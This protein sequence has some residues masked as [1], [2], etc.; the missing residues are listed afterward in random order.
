DKGSSVVYGMPRVAM[1]LGAADFQ[2]PLNQIAAKCLTLL[3]L[4]DL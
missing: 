1:E 3:R 4:N 2:L